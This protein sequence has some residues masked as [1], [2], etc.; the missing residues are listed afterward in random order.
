MDGGYG[1]DERDRTETVTVTPNLKRARKLH[2][3]PRAKENEV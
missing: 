2:E 3:N 1:S